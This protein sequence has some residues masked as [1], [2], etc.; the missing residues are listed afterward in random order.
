MFTPNLDKPFAQKINF[1]VKDNP[2]IFMINAKGQGVN[3]QVDFVPD[4]VK[5]GPVLPYSNAAM[6]CIEM[7]NPMDIPI[8]V[9]SL[10]FDKLYIEEEEIL[11]RLEQFQLP[12]PQNP[13]A[14]PATAPPPIDPL[15]LSLRMPGMQFWT[16]LR[17]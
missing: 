13:P 3:Y 10:D 17:Q 4:A 16:L 11:K 5:L 1:K 12:A 6:A 15:F 9:Y 14:T 7:R 8:E 2:K